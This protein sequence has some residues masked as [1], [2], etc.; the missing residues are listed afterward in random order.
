MDGPSDG[1]AKPVK[2]STT[3]ERT[4]DRDVFARRTVNGPVR[5][6]FEAWTTPALFARWWVPRSYGL[7][8]LSCEM[9]VRV[10]GQYRLVFKH[11]DSTMAFYGTYLEVVPNSR[12]VWTNEESD[13]GHTV[14][15]VTFEEHDGTTSIVVHDHH[16]SKESLESGSMDAMPE[17]FE[18]LD[19]LLVSLSSQKS[20]I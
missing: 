15:T 12:L 17:A 13:E 1:S 10:G 8:L 18:Q 20:P 7:T 9:D 4:S 14:T 19:E 3:V 11:E 16:P 6:V 5:L 2:H